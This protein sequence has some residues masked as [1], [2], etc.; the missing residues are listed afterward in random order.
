MI[1]IGQNLY[2]L[3]MRLAVCGIVIFIIYEGTSIYITKRRDK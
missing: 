1:E 3:M 2:D